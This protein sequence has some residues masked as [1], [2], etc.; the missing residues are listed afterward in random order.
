[1]RSM[2]RA[3]GKGTLLP[4][5]SPHVFLIRY[6]SMT[7][8]PH[9]Y[10]VLVFNWHEPYICLYAATAHRFDVVPPKGHPEKRWNQGF[11]PLPDNAVEVS[12]QQA[13][14]GVRAGEYDLILCLTL[15]DVQAVQD[16]EVPRLF[17][18]LNMIGTDTGL[19]GAEKQAYIERLQP[20][21]REVDIAFISEKKRRDWGWEA[22]VVVSGIEPDDYAGYTGEWARVLRAGHMLKERDPMQ[23]FGIQEEILG[24]DIPSSIVGVNPTLPESRPSQDWED[25]KEQYRKHRVVLCTLAEAHEDG[26]NLAVLEAM[27]TGMPVVSLANRSSPIVDGVNGFI[28]ADLQYLREK[29]RLLLAD[30]EL[31]AELGGRARETVREKFHIRDCAGQWNQVFADCIE[32]WREK[33]EGNGVPPAQPATGNGP[34]DGAA[35]AAGPSDAVFAEGREEVRKEAELPAY[36]Q[37]QRPEIAALIPA[38]ARRVLEIGCAAGEMGGTLKQ[39]RPGV[40]VVG[41]EVD[42]DAARLARGKLDAVI[43]GDIEGLE[44]LPYPAGYFDCITC[45]DVLE[46]LRDPEAALRKLLAYLHPAGCLVCSIPNIRHQSVLLDLLVNGRW[47][48]RDEG[49]LDCTHLRFF[50]LTEIRAL[51]ERL[52]LQLAQVTASQSPVLPQM[53]PLYRAAAELGGDAEVLRQE[54]RVIQYIFRAVP[55]ETAHGPRISIVVPVFNQAEYTEQCLHALA[56]STEEELE[57]EVVVVDNGSTDWTTYL[58]HAFEGDLRVLRNDEN[59]GFARANNQGAAGAR[60]EYVVFLNNDTLPRPGWLRAL[61]ELA[62]SDPQISA[63]GAKLLYPGTTQVQHAGLELRDGVPKHVHHGIEADD[64][65]VDQV[66]DLDMVTGACMLV[67]RS[68]FAELDGFD[69]GYMNG[70]EDVDLCLRMRERGNRVVYCPTS[71]V[72]H[73]EGTSEGRFDQACDNLQRF[74]E[75]WQGRFDAAGRLQTA[76]D[77]KEETPPVFRGNWE[78][79]FFVHSSLAHVNRELVLALLGSGRCEL[80]LIPFEPHQFGV[81]EDPERLMAIAERLER[82]LAGEVDFHIRHRWPPDFSRPAAGRLVLI[83]PWEFGRIPQSWVQPLRENVDQVWAYTEH[84]RQCYLDSGIDPAQVQVVPLG[85]DTRNFRP[86]LEP[87]ELPTDKRFKFL[88][89]GGTLFRKGI[90]VL[91]EAYRTRFTPG[92]DVCLVIKDMGVQTFYSGHNAGEL[93]RELREDPACP[94][95]VYL[96][97]D[98]PST[99]IARLYAA[100][101]C[102]VHPYRGEGFGLPVAEAMACGL[103]VIVTAG[104]ACD[105]FCSSENGYM[106]PALRRQVRYTEE[107]AG[108]PWLL[109]PDGETLKCYLR[110]VIEEPERARELGQRGTERIQRDFTWEKAAERVVEVLEELVAHPGKGSAGMPLSPISAAERRGMAAI[111]LGGG[112]TAAIQTLATALDAQVARYDVDLQAGASLGDQLE[113]IRQDSEGEFV[114]LME[115]GTRCSV[116]TWSQLLG[117]LRG[118]PDI[119][120]VSPCLPGETAGTG[121]EDSISLTSGCAIVRRTALETVEGFEPAFRTLAAVDEAARCCRHRGWRAV[122][123]LG[124]FLESVPRKNGNEAEVEAERQAVRALEEG[125][126]CKKAG[127]FDGAEK[128]YRRAL[129]AKENYVEP[130]VVLGSLLMEAGRPQ[131]AVEVIER[132]VQLDEQSFQAHNYLGLAQYQA[133]D[134]EGARQSF[135][136]ALEAHPE[137]VETLV[138]LSVLEWG[139]ENAD[140]ALDYLEQAAALEPGN[141]DVIVNTGLI[142]VQAGN[143]GAALELFRQYVQAHPGDV[144]VMGLLIDILVQTDQ[145]E[146]ARQVAERILEMQP[147]HAKARAIVESER[148]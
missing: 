56:A 38:E 57:Y 64:P 7:K 31:A 5:A 142:Q 21:F 34:G 129:E 63:V 106:I 99:Q 4:A 14:A 32:R 26:Y 136:R 73:H 39:E 116:E 2:M 74:T 134:W 78:G 43:C 66:R 11:R 8:F 41:V 23:G 40:E 119:A 72:E 123:V 58:L 46:H 69:T 68:V 90:D 29:L 120:L 133:Q 131:E 144:E 55:R 50:T 100:C 93:I 42:E 85:V 102:L 49:L 148:G 16:W 124:C 95:I 79:A 10:R 15:R 51:F 19:R 70:V 132:L 75:K 54:A 140:R 110:Q 1:M 27:A 135:A 45:G 37:N 6:F 47:Q 118:H 114:V 89:V 30:R 28:S 125:D 141:R 17:V 92:D 97:E 128:A 59:L 86:G 9:R 25:L 3:G 94:E 101:D 61:V 20:L 126:C 53:E 122:R 121:L 60:G 139:Q 13:E 130:I 145:L 143:A 109:E 147:R 83:Q 98:L 115:Q 103:P 35:L 113:V 108:S 107:T 87:L 71:V 104:G 81:E 67:R 127:N 12:W 77:A 112:E 91:L 80:G 62:D 82:P 18:M 84:V 24:S 137:Y 96:T 146:E 111:V 65:R 44:F 117:T 52:G 33:R 48:Y 105:D 36:Y 76:G 22:P 138:N 88:F